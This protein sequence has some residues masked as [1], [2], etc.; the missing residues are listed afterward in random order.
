MA[1][2]I[3]LRQEFARAQLGD[4]RLN[5][6]LDT[7][8]CALQ[9]A[10]DRSFPSATRSS[11][12]LEGAYRFFRNERVS[13]DALIA[14][15]LDATAGRAADEE[16]AVL[17]LHDT[18]ELRFGGDQRREGLGTLPLAGQGFFGHFALVVSGDGERRPLGIGGIDLVVRADGPA[19]RLHE[20]DY[21]KRKAMDRESDRW[22]EMVA[23]VHARLGGLRP[24]HVMDR[25][26]DDFELLRQMVGADCRF[27]VRLNESRRRKG[28]RVDG[29]SKAPYVT[30]I[31]H[32][33]ELV[34]TREVELSR[35][36]GHHNGGSERSY[37]RREGRIATLGISAATID[38]APP[39][40][41]VRQLEPLRLQVV[42]VVERKAPRGE[43]PVEWVLMTTEAIDSSEQVLAIVDTYRARWTIEEYFKALKTGCAIERRQLE[44][45]GALA[46]ALGVLAP[47][48]V[49]LL[50]L[51]SRARTH[52]TES[53]TKLLS[54]DELAALRALARSRLPRS[55]TTQDALLAIA[56]LGGHIKQNGSPGWLVLARGYEKLDIAVQ[57]LAA[58]SDEKPRQ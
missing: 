57:V 48:A 4:R 27:V 56:G 33:V 11:A 54:S 46:A 24:I 34:A 43:T 6:R 45:G 10:P 39:R 58:I 2:N 37:P 22:G 52:P 23:E 19:R 40:R 1:S 28:T 38:V 8:V 12:E 35:R 53:A 50:A 41:L 26:A 21:V 25:E 29:R 7:L 16:A 5:A 15:H 36:R 13:L 14:P 32:G 55:P 9:D 3:D 31:M 47:M 42:R 20:V 44:T 17:V 49:R 30:E 18:T 51:R